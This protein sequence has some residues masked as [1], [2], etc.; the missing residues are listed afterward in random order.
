METPPYLV[1]QY[2]AERGISPMMAKRLLYLEGLDTKARKV[3][4]VAGMLGLEV[5]T[6]KAV[7]R[8]LIIDFSDYR[9][10]ARRRDAGEEVVPKLREIRAPANGLP[11][12]GRAA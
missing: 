10:Y 12:F 3:G 5:A 11:L 6:L 8:K 2:A 7:A 4:D 1:D 9:P